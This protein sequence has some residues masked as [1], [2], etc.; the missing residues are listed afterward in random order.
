MQ[1]N[2]ISHVLKFSSLRTTLTEEGRASCSRA[3]QKPKNA[4]EG[5][6]IENGTPKSTSAEK[7]FLEWPKVGKQTLCIHNWQVLSATI[8]TAIANNNSESLNFWL[9]KLVK[10]YTGSL[11][12]RNSKFTACVIWKNI[13]YSPTFSCVS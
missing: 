8:D 2:Q 5:K 12:L 13:N 11:I 3:F 1:E 9:I 10:E 6:F 4:E 7:N